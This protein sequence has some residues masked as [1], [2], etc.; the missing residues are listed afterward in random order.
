MMTPFPATELTTAERTPSWARDL[1]AVERTDRGY[2]CYALTRDGIV[3]GWVY[4]D[5]AGYLW[6]EGG[7]NDIPD[8]AVEDDPRWKA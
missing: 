1:Q 5:G 4:D 2:E 6:S 7:E 8:A 3:V